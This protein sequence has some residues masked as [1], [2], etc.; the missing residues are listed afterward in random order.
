MTFKPY[1][2]SI[3]Y[4]SLNHDFQKDVSS[5]K[6]K[7]LCSGPSF[8]YGVYMKLYNRH[9]WLQGERV[10]TSPLSV[11]GW[12]IRL[13]LMAPSGGK[14]VNH[15]FLGLDFVKPDFKPRTCLV[16]TLDWSGVRGLMTIN[17]STLSTK[18]Q[19]SE[20]WTGHR[21][22]LVATIPM[23]AVS[24]KPVVMPTSPSPL[25]SHWFYKWQALVQLASE[26]AGPLTPILPQHNH[27][28]QDIHFITEWTIQMKAVPKP[29]I[30]WLPN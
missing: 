23:V 28:E 4:F 16:T 24:Q 17:I 8:I 30:W 9:S 29:A 20:K 15:Q 19:A 3:C 12:F 7:Q 14:E 5:F 11:G 2:Y 26:L 13:A 1:M 18:I 22:T 10:K 25:D 21:K 27:R 6:E